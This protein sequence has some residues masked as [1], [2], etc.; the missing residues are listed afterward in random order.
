MRELLELDPAA[1][2]K[3]R[4]FITQHS[5]LLQRLMKMKRSIDVNFPINIISDKPFAAIYQPFQKQ[6]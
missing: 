4:H 3:G 5:L 1:E 6:Q 2:M